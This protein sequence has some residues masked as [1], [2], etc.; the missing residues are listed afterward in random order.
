[1]ILYNFG[2]TLHADATQEVIKELGYSCEIIKN[3][4]LHTGPTFCG[5]VQDSLF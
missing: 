1:M 2:S 3:P 4:D 5:N